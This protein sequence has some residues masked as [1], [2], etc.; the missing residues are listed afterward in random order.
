MTWGFSAREAEGE[1]GAWSFLG[2][3]LLEY[4]EMGDSSIFSSTG[5][6]LVLRRIFLTGWFGVVTE[7]RSTSLSTS[8]S[9]GSWGGG[10]R[11]GFSLLSSLLTASGLS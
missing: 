11:S 5:T 7:L 1:K 9:G 8:S 6:E 3:V 2:R 4:G 10:G